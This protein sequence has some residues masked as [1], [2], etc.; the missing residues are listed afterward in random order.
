MLTVTRVAAAAA[1]A[2]SAPRYSVRLL[3]HHAGLCVGAGATTGC[4]LVRFAM[5]SRVAREGR[6]GIGKISKSCRG[7]TDR[8]AW[9]ARPVEHDQDAQ[10]LVADE[11]VVGAS[12]NEGRITFAKRRLLAFDLQ[13]A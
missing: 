11:A 8:A 9:S 6:T 4:R 13:A 3:R 5:S 7:N 1:A 10:V 12:R 2:P